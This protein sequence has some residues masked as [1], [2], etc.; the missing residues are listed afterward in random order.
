MTV[1][2]LSSANFYQAGT[3]TDIITVTLVHP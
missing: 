1:K 2:V 3:Y